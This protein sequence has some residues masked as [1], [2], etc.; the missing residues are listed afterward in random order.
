M[1]CAL[2]CRTI[3]KNV[4]ERNDRLNLWILL[5]NWGTQFLIPADWIIEKTC[6][7]SYA[8]FLNF[9]SNGGLDCF[10]RS[11]N[12]DLSIFT[13]NKQVGSIL[14]SQKSAKW[15][16]IWAVQSQENGQFK[17]IYIFSHG[18]AR[19]IKF[20]QLINL[21]QIVLLGTLPQEVVTS[22]THNHMTWQMYLSL[23]TEGLL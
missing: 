22:L 23:V 8:W 5:I 16:P 17:N 21:S 18:E 15:I 7:R 11:N 2:F 3:Q 1:H 19:N 9:L 13:I 12:Y 6:A 20:G 14:T 4:T 10:V